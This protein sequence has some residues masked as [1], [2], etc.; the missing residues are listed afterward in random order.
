MAATF[1]RSL[2]LALLGACWAAAPS[3][4]QRVPEA[5]YVFPPGGK[6][7]TTVEVRLGG[8]DWTPDMDYFTLDS[9]VQLAAD[10]PP[11]P[12]WIPPPPYWFGPKGRLPA[13]PLPREVSARFVI[14][15]DMPPGPI[16]WQ[17]A[18]A[19]GGTGTGV[20][21]VG[22]GQEL[23]ED[24][25]RREPQ[26][27]SSLPA[28][29]S[30]RISKIEEIDRYRIVAARAGPI[31]CELA[32]RR[33]G[34]GLQGV[35]EVRD[36][37][38]KLAAEALD[39]EGLDA[40]ATFFAAAGGTY[41]IAVRDL[42]H[43]GD[44]SFVYRL[45]IL[46]GPRVLAALPAGG[47]RGETRE[48]EFVGLGVASGAIQVESAKRQVTFPA[49]AAASSLSYSLETPFGTAPAFSL[50]VGDL[51][52]IVEPSPAAEPTKLAPPQA[53][54]GRLD[55]PQAVDRYRW[56]AKQGEHWTIA[57]DAR[58]IHS[59]LDVSLSIRGADGKE[60]AANDDL[61]GTTDAGLDFVAPADGTYEAAVSDISGRRQAPSAVYR[62]AIRRAA[63]DF[64]LEV[65][66]RLN[67]LVGGTSNLTVK[68]V[69][70]GGWTGPITLSIA[71][72]PAGIQAPAEL[73]VPVDKGD[74][75]VVLT[76]APDAVAAAALISVRG[77]AQ[78][79]GQAVTRPALAA[80]G[81]NLAPRSPEE[82]HVAKTLL[83]CTMKPRCAG[84]PV[85]QDTVRK[86]HRGA[87]FPAEVL[88]D[89]LEGFEGPIVLSMAAVQSYQVQ[90]ITGPEV[91]VPPGV[92]RTAYP[93]FMPE[94]LETIRTSRMGMIATVEVPD[95]QGRVRHLVAPIT[96]FITMTIEGALLRLSHAEGELHAATGGSFDVRI[97][98]ARATKLSR[99]VRLE[100]RLPEEL[101]GLVTAEPVEIPAGQH[102]ADFR[103]TA[104]A[105]PRLSGWQTLTV[106]GTALAAPDLPV[107]SETSIEVEFQ[108]PTASR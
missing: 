54:T 59:P 47:R 100:L 106:R 61:A 64:A 17:A 2:G 60:L 22:T 107:V 69:R 46:P 96:G 14:P 81:G 57:V 34:S 36:A 97:K 82:N 78:V 52:E 45:S 66:Q 80:A 38:G 41:E 102:E 53:V 71:G 72:L 12:I 88:V 51:A 6:A 8:Y 98:L 63:A 83:A 23:V 87:T 40:G 1:I 55:G 30:G 104:S 10:G 67:V 103:V 50:L 7:G 65:P 90:G 27:I 89:R 105:D 42:D 44:R 28:T 18:N 84:R 85:D 75:A 26:S 43:A 16:R 39:T 25:K 92:T 79:D 9:R 101:A 91:V 32:A 86:A 62:L 76:A 4:A 49:D 15:P 93:C 77:E 99:P 108:A 5:G 21:V 31:T 29:I 33:I 94:W 58:R 3:A 56:D 95:A 68:A 11:G 73:V 35:I 13:L 24:E 20:F 48:I 37:S 19:N 70:R 74:L